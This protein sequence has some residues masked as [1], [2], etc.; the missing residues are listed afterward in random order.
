MESDDDAD[1]GSDRT[2]EKR[3]EHGTALPEDSTDIGFEQKQGN[4][5]G[6]E[7]GPDHIIDGGGHGKDSEV[8]EESR[9]EDGHHGS[10]NLAPP[11][12]PFSLESEDGCADQH[13]P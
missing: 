3:H 5:Q 2:G 8:A 9:G 10:G 11:P 7:V 4:R 6:H 12:G 13:G 1:H